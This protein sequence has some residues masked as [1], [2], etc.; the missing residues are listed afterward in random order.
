MQNLVQWEVSNLNNA[1]NWCRFIQ[2]QIV[3]EITL[4]LGYNF[5]IV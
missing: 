2:I 1:N 3:L 4:K 5:P